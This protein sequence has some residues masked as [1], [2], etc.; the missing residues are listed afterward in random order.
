MKRLS[1]TPR[2]NWEDRIK[3][4]GF[5]FYKGYYN[6][7]AAYEFSADEVDRIE[8]ATKELFDRCLDVVQHVI[9]ND[10]WDEFFI[11][12]KYADLI[13]WSWENDNPAFYGRFDLA[14]DKDCSDIKLLEFNADTPTSLL[15]ASV[16]QWYWL[17]E[18]SS[19]ADQFNSI[20]EK[21][22]DHLKVCKDYLYGDLKLWFSCVR[23]SDEDFMTVK[24]LQDIADQANI[25]NRFL[26]IDEIGI[27]NDSYLNT[28]FVNNK[29]EPINNIFKLYPYEWLFNEQFGEQLITKKDLTL[30]IEPPYKA[31]LSN[32]MLL[33]YLHK[34]F[35]DHPNILPAFYSKEETSPIQGDYVQKPVYGRE[36]SNVSI[37]KDATLA[38]HTKGDYG[39]EGWVYQ[40]YFDIPEF[41]GRRPVIGSWLIGGV[42]AGM[43]IKETTGLIH[44]NMSKFCPHYFLPRS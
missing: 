1:I 41:D 2:P 16:I 8:A 35:P 13:K 32:K 34:L 33:V 36:G 38:E 14:M 43:G 40:Q 20:H 25:K 42:S 30:W 23:S 37:V 18:Y 11:P 3:V 44:S 24:Y 7:T 15:E 10:L 27:I 19:T 39:E 29:E 28:P 22:V 31:I 12:R 6:E 21:L 17:Q 5:V 9:D 4:Q 26:Y